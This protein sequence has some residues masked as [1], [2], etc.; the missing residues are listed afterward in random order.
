MKINF[1]SSS[2]SVF[3]WV[4]LQMRVYRRRVFFFLL[5]FSLK[6]PSRQ[7]EE[8]KSIFKFI[9]NIISVDH[10]KFLGQCHHP[11]LITIFFTRESF[12]LG[13]C[14]QRQIFERKKNASSFLLCRLFEN[15]KKGFC[16]KCS[17]LIYF[18]KN[19]RIKRM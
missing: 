8:K 9:S 19:L 3:A 1:F 14:F 15:K 12:Y 10:F 16:G 4:Y 11:S 2:F 13:V 6:T 18:I 17:R 7:Q 5:N